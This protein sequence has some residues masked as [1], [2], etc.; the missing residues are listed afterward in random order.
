MCCVNTQTSNTA[1]IALRNRVKIRIN[2]FHTGQGTQLHS[3]LSM[4]SCG[5][6]TGVRMVEFAGI[7]PTPFAGMLLA[8]LRADVVRI[9]RPGL[10]V[11]DPTNITSRGKRS[12]TVCRSGWQ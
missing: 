7:G 8:D 11:A 2:R 1:Q 3:P 10:A 4:A 12:I 6:L 9:D 5:P